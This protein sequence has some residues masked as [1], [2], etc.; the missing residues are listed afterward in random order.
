MYVLGKVLLGLGITLLIM[1]G[2]ALVFG[3]PVL[4]GLICIG[5][6]PVPMIV[7]GIALIRRAEDRARNSGVMPATEANDDLAVAQRVP[8]GITGIRQ[9]VQMFDLN[10]LNWIGWLLL[11]ATFGFALAVAA[12]LVWMWP[13]QWD[14]QYK[15]LAGT[16]IFFMAIGFFAGTRWLLSRLRVSIYRQE[17]DHA[18]PGDEADG[19]A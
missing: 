6:V 8:T 13:D 19:G 12:A 7:V 1:G 4:G 3:A 16:I 18:E 10:S 2:V 11:L 9:R 17:R 5:C 15:K 14:R